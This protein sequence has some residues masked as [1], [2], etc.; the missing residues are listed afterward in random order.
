[1]GILWGVY[2][3][4]PYLIAKYSFFQNLFLSHAESQ[5]RKEECKEEK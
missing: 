5:S 2:L 1:V 3:E 4:F